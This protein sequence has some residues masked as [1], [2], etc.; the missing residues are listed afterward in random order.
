MKGTD[1]RTVP[2][3]PPAQHDEGE[4]E[5]LAEFLGLQLDDSDFEDF[6][7]EDFRMVCEVSI[8]HVLCLLLSFEQRS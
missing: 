1:C 5:D 8:Q 4:G 6:E 3:N 7:F 2:V